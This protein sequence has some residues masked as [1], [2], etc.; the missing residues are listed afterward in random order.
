MPRGSRRKK[1]WIKR[2]I[3]RKAMQSTVRQLSVISIAR[4]CSLPFGYSVCNPPPGCKPCYGCICLNIKPIKA[5]FLVSLTKRSLKNPS[6]SSLIVTYF[7]SVWPINIV[8]C[9]V[10]LLALIVCKTLWP[11]Q[12]T[13]NSYGNAGVMQ[14]CNAEPALRQHIFNIKP[15]LLLHMLQGWVSAIPA[16]VLMLSQHYSSTC[17]NAEPAILL[18]IFQGCASNIPAH[19]LMLNQQ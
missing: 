13:I 14:R 19:F 17:L 3:H 6:I 7:I 10:F 8:V 15:A 11:N 2:A 1:K 9:K 5:Q 18:H 12:K 16:H 4:L